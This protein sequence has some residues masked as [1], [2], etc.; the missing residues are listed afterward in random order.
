MYKLKR[1]ILVIGF[2]VCLISLTA[3]NQAAGQTSGG[4]EVIT[5][6][7][8]KLHLDFLAADELRGRDT[9]SNELKIASKYLSLLSKSYGLKPIM[10]DGS[11]FQNVPLETSKIIERETKI[12]LNGSINYN[13]PSDFGFKRGMITSGTISGEI[14]F[15]GYGLHAPEASWDDIEGFKVKGKIVLIMDVNLPE[16][17]NIKKN[18][19]WRQRRGRARLLMSRG[20][21]A[22]F[23]IISAEEEKRFQDKELTFDNSI[24][25]R[26]SES[27][28]N[29]KTSGNGSPD[30]YYVEIR[31]KMAG[32]LLGITLDDLTKMFKQIRKGEPVKGRNIKDKTL[33]LKVETQKKMVYTRNVVACLE[34]SDPE[35]KDEYVVLGAHYDHLG[36]RKGEIYNGSND[37]ASGSVAILVLAK[38]MANQHPRRSVIFVWF[39]GEEKGLWGSREF[40]DNSPVPLEKIS[41][42]INL[43]VCTGKDFT[44]LTTIGGRKLSSELA[45]IMKS[46]N[47]NHMNIKFDYKFD[48][49]SS[50]LFFSSDHFTFMK[51]G[52]PSVWLSTAAEP[53]THIHQPTDT[54]DRSNGKKVCLIS[55]FSYYLALQIADKDEMLKLDLNPEITARGKH[56][57]S[58]DWEKEKKLIY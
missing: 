1:S 26:Y 32:E 9:P 33:K 20:A 13:F 3:F 30:S 37:N 48:F 19:G 44:K 36:V 2:F 42:F 4:V 52:I 14:V 24:Q 35:L 6:Q 25:A 12:V 15:L 21:A 47:D 29:K 50:M 23:S 40:V 45:V 57:L 41:A 38:A 17:H 39:T 8:L 58:Y 5:T 27:Q 7:E 43:D 22:V 49:P 53:T 34:G 46:V 10:S 56:N 54:P 28:D 16:E 55:H 51:H 18:V 11:Y 31:H